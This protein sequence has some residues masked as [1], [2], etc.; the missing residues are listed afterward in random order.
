MKPVMFFL[1]NSIDIVRGGLT[2][3]ALNQASFFAEMGYETH[4]LTF[5]FNTK[6]PLIRKKLL[7][8]DK[9]H[10]DVMIHNM[11]ETFE[12]YNEPLI[13]TEPTK[14]RELVE[15]SEGM[16]MDKREGHNAY[17]LFKNGL[18]VKYISLNE[19]GSI[20][21][22]DFFN[23]N[24][25]RT[26]REEYDPWGNLKKVTY[27]DLLLNKPRQ[28]IYYDNDGKAYFTQ[29]NDPSKNKVQRILLFNKQG[30]LTNTFVNDNFSHKL[31]W[32][33]NII[34]K[35]VSNKA[36]IVSDARNTDEILIKF[37]HPNVAKIWRLHSGHLGHPYNESAEIAS[38]VEMGFNNINTFDAAVLLTEEQRVDIEKRIGPQRNLK[39]IPHYHKTQTNPFKFIFS[40]IKR[41]QKLAIV[42]SR[43]A[44]MKR[45]DHIIKGFKIVVEKI[46]EARLEIWGYGDQKDNL[47][48]LI[49][50]LHLGKNIQIKGFTQDPDKKY[51]KASFSVMASKQEGF[52]LSILESMSNQTPV[53]SYD[54]KYGPSDMIKSGEN[55][56]VVENGN[57]EELAN[58]MIYL[59]ENPDIA[60]E[61]GKKA[62][63]HV[64]KNF[65]KDKYKERWLEVVDFALKQKFGKDY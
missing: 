15:L 27:M 40:P 54:F 25:Y 60:L 57:I 50:E 64:E 39:V 56:F 55:G 2:K 4:I 34:D 14:K 37:N 58:K 9:V 22:I 19:D 8:L 7:E 6:Y 48:R 43:F 26:K 23:E 52:C 45:I 63:K 53:I 16:V 12:G 62:K 3:A 46:P 61:M 49:K 10:K 30:A 42:I 28:I 32:L 36:V 41:D 24:R 18:Y 51:Q 65:G 17:R 13:I 59:F 5:N 1:V 20:H 33:Q 38:T 47:E 35:F 11:Y 21:F 29:W 31:H 44:T